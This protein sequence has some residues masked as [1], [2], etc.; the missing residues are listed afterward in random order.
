MRVN[1]NLRLLCILKQVMLPTPDVVRVMTCL[2]GRSK[3][4][5]RFLCLLSPHCLMF[6]MFYAIHSR[7]FNYNF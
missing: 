1:C 2:L 6:K 4:S 5:R 3:D 7:L